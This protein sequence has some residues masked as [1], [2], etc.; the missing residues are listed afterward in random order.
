MLNAMYGHTYCSGNWLAGVCTLCMYKLLNHTEVSS[1]QTVASAQW[2][3]TALWGNP[4]LN[5]SFSLYTEE[6]LELVESTRVYRL[7]ETPGKVWVWQGVVDVIR[8]VASAL[9]ILSLKLVWKSWSLCTTDRGTLRVW[10]YLG[11]SRCCVIVWC[12]GSPANE[13][14]IVFSESR[15]SPMQTP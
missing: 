2:F 8:G 5:H 15:N 10:S 14:K 1:L 12:A 3:E 9:G 11:R 7:A 4:K 13:Y 6:C